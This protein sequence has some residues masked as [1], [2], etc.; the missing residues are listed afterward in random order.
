MCKII[1]RLLFVNAF[2][3]YLRSL[4]IFNVIM[5]FFLLGLKTP[6]Y[7]VYRTLKQHVLDF[8]NLSAKTVTYSYWL[9]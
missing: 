4:Y 2:N 8:K 5:Y 3:F 1:S 7:R 9:I 6:I